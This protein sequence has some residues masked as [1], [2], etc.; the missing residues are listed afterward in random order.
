MHSLSRIF[1]HVM[2]L[3]LEKVNHGILFYNFLHDDLVFLLMFLQGRVFLMLCNCIDVKKQAIC[4][5]ERHQRS[6][7]C[8]HKKFHRLKYPTLEALN[9]LI[10]HCST[11]DD[12]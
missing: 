3:I 4:K 12:M 10:L 8:S 1:Y 6:M 2:H 9:G 7:Y 11:G 5:P